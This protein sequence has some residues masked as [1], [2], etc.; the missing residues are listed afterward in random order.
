MAL[1]SEYTKMYAPIRNAR[2]KKRYAEDAEFREKLKARVRGSDS[3]TRKFQRLSVYGVNETLYLAFLKKQHGGC[4]I[5]GQVQGTKNGRK[6]A[7]DHDHKTK[8]V[9]G[10]LCSN[11]NL[12]LGKFKEDTAMLQKAIEYLKGENGAIR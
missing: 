6:L 12:G 7:V 5:C 1:R 4:A 8:E 3:H 10:L 11:C 2:R 9:R